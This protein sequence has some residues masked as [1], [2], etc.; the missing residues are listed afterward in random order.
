MGD[1]AQSEGNSP[2]EDSNAAP[3]ALLR[4]DGSP[5]LLFGVR[6]WLGEFNPTDHF[7]N[8]NGYLFLFMDGTC[9]VWIDNESGFLPPIKTATLSEENAQALADS[10]HVAKW[11]EAYGTDPDCVGPD[12]EFEWVNFG[13]RTGSFTRNG[14][15]AESEYKE[16]IAAFRNAID[17]LGSPEPQPILRVLVF[18]TDSPSTDSVVHS[19]PLADVSA[20]ELVDERGYDG[21]CGGSVLMEGDDATAFQEIRSQTDGSSGAATVLDEGQHYGVLIKDAMP[22]EDKDGIVRQVGDSTSFCGPS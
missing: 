15:C 8:E 17:E 5:E 4:C 19:W 18:P 16:A 10:L 7:A 14:G 21:G 13:D 22:F 11:S 9:K 20:A 3:S 2:D 1:A 6:M 12:F